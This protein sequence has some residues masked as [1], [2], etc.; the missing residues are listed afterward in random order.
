MSATDESWKEMRSSVFCISFVILL[1]ASG[2]SIVIPSLW[3]YLESE[4]GSKFLLGCDH[5]CSD[6]VKV[7]MVMALTVADG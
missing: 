4:G 3:F 2:F 7:T 1:G 6:F 5:K